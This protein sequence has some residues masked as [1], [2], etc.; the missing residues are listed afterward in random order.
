MGI[1]FQSEIWIVKETHRRR[2]ESAETK[3]L[4]M[5]TGFQSRGKEARPD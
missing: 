3:L 1:C 2:K 4:R 5:L